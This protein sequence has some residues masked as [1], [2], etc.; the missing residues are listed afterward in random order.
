MQ[1]GSKMF[2]RSVAL[3]QRVCMPNV[4]Q[5]V[6]SRMI[7]AVW[8]VCWASKMIL[9]IK[10]QCWRLPSPT[11][12]I[13]VYF[14]PSFTANWIL[15]RWWVWYES[16]NESSNKFLILQYWG[17]VKYHYHEVFKSTFTEAKQIAIQSLDACPIETI[18]HF[19]NWS[20]CFMSAY[21]LGLTGKVAEWVVRKQKSHCSVTQH[22][23][24]AIDSILN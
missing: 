14:C 17:Y 23:M 4:H 15:S 10:L 24:L 11:G 6:P 19:I 7:G 12:D 20:W 18:W 2:L 13:Y 9:S 21:C 16:F 22:A 3:T 5:Y 8:H 1:R